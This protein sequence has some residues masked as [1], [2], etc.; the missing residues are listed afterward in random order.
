MKLGVFISWSG[1][2]SRQLARELKWWLPRVLSPVKPWMSDSDIQKGD[3]WSEQIG[4]QLRDHRVGIICVTPENTSSEWLLFE[5]GALSKT[6]G[7][8]RVCPVLLGIRPTELEGPLTSKFQIRPEGSRAPTSRTR[9]VSIPPRNYPSA[10]TRLPRKR[11]DLRHSCAPV[12]RSALV[13]RCVWISALKL[14]RRS[15]R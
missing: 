6:F 13:R 8:G 12:S 10:T 3:R 7:E 14:E 11:A 1:E 4:H 9:W 15:R 2:R 5:A